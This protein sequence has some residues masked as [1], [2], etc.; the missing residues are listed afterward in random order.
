[1]TRRGCNCCGESHC[2]CGDD[3]DGELYLQF[4]ISGLL[5]SY[6]FPQ[7]GLTPY[8][9]SGLD[10]LNGEYLYKALFAPE[11]C[12]SFEFEDY[13]I[14]RSVTNTAFPSKNTAQFSLFSDFYSGACA[15]S[16][17]NNFSSIDPNPAVSPMLF[18][19]RVACG[20]TGES[21]LVLLKP[22]LPAP[23][24]VQ[25]YVTYP[26]TGGITITSNYR[27]YLESE[28]VIL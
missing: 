21:G 11:D 7:P 16:L 6:S 17:T 5:S 25:P 9:I 26:W 15:A 13:E 1:M 20:P 8:T 2:I 4:T 10:A 14:S 19:N 3:Y 18:Y 27:F 23:V 24:T 28:Y 22:T 12:F